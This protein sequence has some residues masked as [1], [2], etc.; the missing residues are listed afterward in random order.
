V[1]YTVGREEG[2]AVYRG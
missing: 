1:L 2:R